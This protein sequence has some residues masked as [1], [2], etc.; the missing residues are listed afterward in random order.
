MQTDDYAHEMVYQ[1]Q[2]LA[3]IQVPTDLTLSDYE[4]MQS[5]FTF[6]LD[7]L[8]PID[9]CTIT[10]FDELILADMETV[11]LGTADI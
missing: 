4:E 1:V 7:L 11:V 9:P 5:T 8:I 2:I 6:E 3:K 10:R